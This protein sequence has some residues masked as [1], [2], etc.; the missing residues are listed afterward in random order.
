MAPPLETGHKREWCW[1]LLHAWAKW[2]DLGEY[3]L[4]A[5]DDGRNPTKQVLQNGII[6]ERR[7][8][9]CNSAQRQH[10]HP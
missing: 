3:K 8:K 7:C 6:Q 2:A 9:V 1:P 10:V 4:F 5:V